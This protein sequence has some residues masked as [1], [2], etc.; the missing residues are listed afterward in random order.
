MLNFGDS[1]QWG[2]KFSIRFWFEL[3]M[4][5]SL[6][7]S[8]LSSGEPRSNSCWERCQILVSDRQRSLSAEMPQENEKEKKINMKSLFG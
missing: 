1:K 6:E 3:L 2:V 7:V 4:E 5:L 8:L